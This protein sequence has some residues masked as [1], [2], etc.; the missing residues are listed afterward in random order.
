MRERLAQTMAALSDVQLELEQ[1]RRLRSET[2]ALFEL[3]LGAMSDAVVLV[4]ARGKVW[5]VNHSATRLTGLTSDDL[6]GRTVDSIF[7]GAVPATPWDVL[8]RNGEGRLRAFE[9][10]VTGGA[11]FHPVS[12]SCSVLRDA[13]GKVM[14]AVYAARDLSETHHL[15][16]ELEEAEARWR[17]LAELGDVLSRELD[18]QQ[19]LPDVCRWLAQSTGCGVAIVLG[20]GPTVDA[21]VM[22]PEDADGAPT[23]AGLT[24]RPMERGTALWAAA[25]ERRTVHAATLPPDFPLVSSQ[26]RLDRARSA[27]VVPLV[28]RDAT[29]GA[30]VVY[31]AEPDA[32]SERVLAL[33]EEVSARVALALANG[34]LREALT[35]LVAEREAAAFREE[36]L[37]GVSHDMQT[38]LAV[39]VGSIEALQKGDDSAPEWR[40][41]LYSAMSRQGSQLRRLIQQFLDYSRLEA[42]RPIVLRAQPTDVRAALV[43]VQADVGPRRPVIVAAPADLPTAYVDPDRL[44]QVLSNLSSNAVKFSPEGEPVTLTAR[45]TPDTVEIVVADR[46]RGMSPTDLARVF[47]K[48]HRGKGASGTS[49]TG[50]GLYITKAVVEAQGGQLTASS[51]QG[52]GSRFTVVLPRH[53]PR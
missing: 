23:F 27:A 34:Q 47:D 17:M 51:R 42:G 20:S 48:F 1:E 18:P 53:P 37:A 4:D 35:H 21:V 36:L 32:V 45:G 25:Q 44:D 24:G 33:L 41:R 19:S 22:W 3:V 30:L 5:R 10:T 38:P 43:R 9:A 29:L 28:A 52:E 12:L 15:V 11:G 6:I 2:Q 31:A 8:E 46:G 14:G 40:S 50:L 7:G 16:H 39:L 26:R 49:G 13:T